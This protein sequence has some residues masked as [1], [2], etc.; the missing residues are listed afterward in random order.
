MKERR[1]KSTRLVFA[2]CTLQWQQII[3]QNMMLKY[4]IT[5]ASSSP[6]LQKLLQTL[7]PRGIF[8]R[9]TRNR[10]ATIVAHLALDIHLE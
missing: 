1:L 3:M 9:E 8:D 10:G 4:L 2:I 6:V 5:P 7:D